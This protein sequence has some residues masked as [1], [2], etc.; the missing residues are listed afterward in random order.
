M[1]PAQYTLASAESGPKTLFI[2]L[3]PYSIIDLLVWDVNKTDGG[4]F[5]CCWWCDVD[6]KIIKG[7]YCNFSLFSFVVMRCRQD[8]NGLGYTISIVSV[9]DMFYK[10][11]VSI[12]IGDMMV[13]I[14]FGV[15]Q[16]YTVY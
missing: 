14:W 10:M 5:L 11:A 12:D 15:W 3:L 6:C 8:K 2:N 7:N 13:V 1:S 4:V 9:T 16:C